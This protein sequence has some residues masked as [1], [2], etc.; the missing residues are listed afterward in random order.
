MKILSWNCRGLSRPSAIRSLR[1]LIRNFNPDVIFLSETKSPPSQASSILNRLGF[2]LLSQFAPSG[3][4][5]GLLLAWRTG[6]DLDCFVLNKN[7]ISA[8]CYSDPP[9]QPWLLS[10]IYGPPSRSDKPAF[11]DSF[12]SAG[13][14]FVNPWLCIGDLNHVL[15]QSEKYGGRPVASSSNCPF[16]Q[17]IDHFG[18]IDLG[19]SGNPFTWSNNRQDL[20][21]IKERLDRGLATHSWVHLFPEFSLLHIPATSSDHNPI[22]LDTSGSSLSSPRPFKFEEFWT[23]DPS[24]QEVIDAAWQIVVSGN[25]AFCLIKKLKHT[26]LALKRWNSLVFGNIQNKIKS[27]MHQIDMVQQATADP[28]SQALEKKLKSDLEN[29]L[30]QEETLWR[31]KSRE[32]WLTCK[33][34]NTKFFHTSTLIRRR[35]NAVDF[36][37]TNSGNWTSDRLEIGSN[38]VSHF[39][40]LFSSSNSP[41]EDEMLDLF[42]PTITDDENQTLC[43]VPSEL[44]VFQALS[45]FGS[46]KAPGPDG[47]TALF[48][49]RYWSI[50]KFDVLNFVWSF[51]QD[52]ILLKEQNHTFI[53]LIPKQSGSH[54]VHHYRPISL[55]NIVYKLITKI[56]ANRLKILLPKIISPL[57]SAFVPNRNIQDNTILAHELIHSF[58]NKKGKGGF[59]FLKLDMEKAF[60]KME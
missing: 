14:S 56:L 43:S 12:T 38:F 53:A 23:K 40:N 51:F 54:T 9:N 18:F 26:K 25:P 1:V 22:F 21:T 41:I 32:T 46:T 15:D 17:F 60:D 44:E 33:D 34:L 59:M 6:V 8:W 27:S 20:G 19:F 29:L 4:S 52:N 28:N 35:S 37:K 2:Y 45:S 10:C 5:G 7:Y 11:W 42:S 57:Q 55:C 48:Y 36:L 39:S 13:E 50:V 49:K 24:C 30:I 31:N 47:F 3:S 58:K 16:R